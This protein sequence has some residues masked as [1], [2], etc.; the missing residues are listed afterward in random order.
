MC[1]LLFQM[2]ETHEIFMFSYGMSMLHHSWA[3]YP[4]ECKS[5]CSSDT[6]ISMFIAALYP[7]ATMEPTKVPIKG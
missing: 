1:Q 5:E 4:K 2:L 6:C 3:R 7:I